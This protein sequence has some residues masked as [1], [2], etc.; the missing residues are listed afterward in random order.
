MFGATLS[1][2]TMSYFAAALAFL[3]IGETMMVLGYGYPAAAMEAPETLA[4]VHT[5]ALGWLSLLMAG[6]LLQ[7]VPV[8]VGRPLCCTHLAL[9]ALVLLVAGIAGLVV[10]F[11]GL[12]GSVDLPPIA[13]PVAAV[14]T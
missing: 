3:L 9:P 12:S 1:R 6:A 11:V 8:L 14:L 5:I 7:F 13:L 2:W 10:G 4:L